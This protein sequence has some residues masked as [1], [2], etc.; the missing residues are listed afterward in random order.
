MACSINLTEQKANCILIVTHVHSSIIT[1]NITAEST[2]A[3]EK[4]IP[5]VSGQLNATLLQSDVNSDGEI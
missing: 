1:V 2:Y 5:L 3:H 4:T